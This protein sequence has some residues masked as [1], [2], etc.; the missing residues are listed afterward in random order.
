MLTSKEKAQKNEAL[1]VLF[2]LVWK[3]QIGYNSCYSPKKL[4]ALCDVHFSVKNT[5]WVQ[6]LLLFFKNQSFPYNI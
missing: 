4:S 6:Q 2:I 1:C 5:E 3:I